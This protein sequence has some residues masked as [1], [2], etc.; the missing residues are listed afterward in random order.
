M[1]EPVMRV[2]SH[3]PTRH[4]LVKLSSSRLGLLRLPSWE[5]SSCD[6][7]PSLAGLV[8]KSVT[9]MDAGYQDDFPSLA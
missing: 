4:G 7:R 8:R 2:C 9:V 6:V 5:I 3:G 1:K